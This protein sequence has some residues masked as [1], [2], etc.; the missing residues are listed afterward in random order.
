MP[1]PTGHLNG[2]K[3]HLL[4]DSRTSYATAR[5]A[6]EKGR[7]GKANRLGQP[8]NRKKGAS[9]PVFPSFYRV[10][11]NIRLAISDKTTLISKSASLDRFVFTSQALHG[12]YPIMAK[13]A[14]AKKAPT[15]TEILTNLADATGLTRKQVADV[16]EALQA[17]VKKNLGSR[18][19]GVFTIPG[20]LKIQ[21]KKTPAKPKR[22]I[23]SFGE[24]REV[25][26]TPAK[27]KVVV[28]PLKNLKDMV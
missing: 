12:G 24:L 7:Y 3:D 16:F 27:T 23:M 28:R 18:G 2:E 1:Y 8:K 11:T 26:P 14:K 17:E 22:T 5:F 13:A 10:F 4:S 20:L 15:K 19:A 21:K 6:P 9:K 25:G